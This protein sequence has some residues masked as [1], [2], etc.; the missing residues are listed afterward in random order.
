LSRGRDNREDGRASEHAISKHTHN[1]RFRFPPSKTRRRSQIIHVA[2]VGVK[3]HCIPLLRALPVP[4]RSSRAGTFSPYGLCAGA[5]IGAIGVAGL[6]GSVTF[7]SAS[8]KK[9][10]RRVGQGGDGLPKLTH[11]FTDPLCRPRSCLKWLATPAERPEARSVTWLRAGLYPKST[12]ALARP[13]AAGQNPPL[14]L[15]MQ[16]PASAP[17]RARSRGTKC[18]AGKIG[19]PEDLIPGRQGRLGPPKILAPRFGG[20]G[21]SEC[22][23]P[24]VYTC[25]TNSCRFP[26]Y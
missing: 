17:R 6:G 15:A 8:K 1:D 23:R 14:T 26:P 13:G 5:L 19:P 22:A 20:D 9:V 3:N 18:S 11:S 25:Q 7:A 21:Q 16:H 2:T 10:G 24:V 4:P 12:R